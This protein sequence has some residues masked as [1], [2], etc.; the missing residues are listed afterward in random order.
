MSDITRYDSNML[1]PQVAGG[2]AWYDAAALGIEGLGWTDTRHPLDR[3]P[4]R[5]NGKV[6]EGVWNL[7]QHSAGLCV[8]FATDAR[9][10]DARWT[11][12]FENLAMDHM[13]ATGCSG[14]DLYVRDEQRTWRWLGVGRGPRFPVSQ[15]ALTTSLAPRLREYQLYFPLYNGVH[16]VE[17]GLPPDAKMLPAP[18]RIG[19]PICFYGTSIVQ[20]GCAS[21]PGMAYPAI[22]GRRLDRGII[23]LGFSGSGRA[24]HEMADL[25]AEL[26]PA[27]FVIDC[28]PNLDSSIAP[29]TNAERLEY[30]IRSLLSARPA[31]PILFIEN[32]VYQNQHLSR[33]MQALRASR[34]A[35]WQDAYR[36][37]RDNPPANLDLL[38]T[39]S[40]DHLLGDDCDATVDGAH[41]T[42]LGFM[43][44]ADAVEPLLRR[45]LP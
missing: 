37:L 36:R 9:G 29:A 28:L 13:P 26:D 34:N 31:T 23:N 25:L 12:R 11:L 22:L 33:D 4:A 15:C 2:V 20:G 32:I 7:C 42:D 24:E 8:R 21:R 18:S 35:G 27:A 43:R 41:P 10:L 17:I 6:T 5:A 45:L 30:L 14:V 38:H 44:I 1:V 16:Q 19:K 39:L 3:L 40:G